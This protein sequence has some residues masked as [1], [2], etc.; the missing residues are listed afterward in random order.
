MNF[1]KALLLL[2]LS[3]SAVVSQAQAITQIVKT[4][5]QWKA[6]LTKEQYA[7]TRQKGTETPYKNAYWD[8]HK[9]GVYRCVCCD[10]ELFQSN[11]K[12]DSGTGWPSFSKPVNTE[13]VTIGT[14]ESLGMSRDEVSCSRCGAHLGHVFDDGPEPTGK[15]YCM[16]SAALKFVKK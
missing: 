15:R 11:A 2:S 5:A 3:A 16:N 9:E 6:Q 12:F 14:D 7:V 10:L 4:D 1:L 13:N 8:N